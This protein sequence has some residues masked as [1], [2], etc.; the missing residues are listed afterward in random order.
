MRRF[1]LAPKLFKESL[2]NCDECKEKKRGDPF[3]SHTDCVLATGMLV[4]ETAVVICAAG[5]WVK[6][7]WMKKMAV[8]A[9]VAAMKWMEDA[10]M[11]DAFYGK[12][13]SCTRSKRNW[14]R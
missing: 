10:F 12:E 4:K 11:E 1:L 2:L 13:E 7:G 9:W 3:F 5:M 14:R 8:T 6:G